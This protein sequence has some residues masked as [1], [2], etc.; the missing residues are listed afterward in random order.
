MKA[1]KLANDLRVI[2]DALDK[3]P[4]IEV[5]PYFDLSAKF[6]STH[7]EEKDRFMALAKVWPRPAKKEIGNRGTTFESYRIVFNEW[8]ILSIDRSKVCHLVEPA[9][10]AVYDCPS[11]LTDEEEAQL[12]E[13]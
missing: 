8:A 5:N 9:R 3:E 1:S 11:I 10:P 6:T 4:D 13:F 2:A 7:A 12:G